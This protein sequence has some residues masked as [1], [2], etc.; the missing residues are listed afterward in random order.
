MGQRMLRRQRVLVAS[1]GLALL[2]ACTSGNATQNTAVHQ[3][4]LNSFQS[5]VLADGLVTPAEYRRAVSAAKDCVTARGWQ[6]S[7]LVRGIDGV[8]LTFSV[9][10]GR[11]K[12]ADSVLA[13]IEADQ[14][15][16]VGQNLDAIEVVYLKSQAPTGQNRDTQ[17]H[18][19]VRCLQDAG[20]SDANVAFTEQQFVGSIMK[21]LGGH[22]ESGFYCMDTHAGLFH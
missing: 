11:K 4:G 15:S 5:S 22:P 20:V 6:T 3:T 16:C 2:A 13:K 21:A 18:E 14:T 12:V 1:L 17:L 19:L 8:S 9:H 7:Q 10:A